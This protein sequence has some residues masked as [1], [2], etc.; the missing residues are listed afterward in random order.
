L[1]EWDALLEK[2]DLAIRR[3]PRDVATRWNSTFDMM[4][5]ALEYRPAIE[6]FTADRK[7]GVRNLELSEAEWEI[8][9]QLCDV[10]KVMFTW[11]RTHKTK[12]LLVASQILKDATL[13]FSRA[14]PNLA[15]VIPAMDEIE[16]RFKSMAADT[17]YN[18]AVRYAL[19]LATATL[20]KYYSL[21]DSSEAYRIAMGES[22]IF[23]TVHLAEQ[24]QSVLHPRHK[25]EYFKTQNWEAD[26]IATAQEL[27]REEYNR[28]YAQD[29]QPVEQSSDQEARGP[30]KVR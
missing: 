8:G 12:H 9:G 6:A 26:W 4:S 14:T 18:P 28:T 5:V 24:T 29:D 19:R 17:K 1:P 22:L 20:N 11:Q 10:L 7:N 21:T 27:V 15:V 16:R 23:L 13:F 2:L 25:L 30:T 3:I